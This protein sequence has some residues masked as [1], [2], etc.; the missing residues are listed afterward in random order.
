MGGQGPVKAAEMF[1]VLLKDARSRDVIQ[2]SYDTLTDHLEGLGRVN[3][4]GFSMG[5]HRSRLRNGM[6]NARKP[7]KI[8]EHPT[9][10]NENARFLAPLASTSPP[11]LFGRPHGAGAAAHRRAAHGA[12]GEGEP[13]EGHP[14]GDAGGDASGAHRVAE[15][16]GAAGRLKQGLVLPVVLRKYEVYEEELR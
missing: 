14:G 6:K 8:H 12:A 15:L 9:K 2:T 1:Q 11:S 5:F 13:R 10:I 7:E 3:F 4:H 16:R